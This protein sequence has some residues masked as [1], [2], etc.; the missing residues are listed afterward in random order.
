[1]LEAGETV[2]LEP[3]WHNLLPAELELTGV[4]SDATGPPGPVY[5]IVDGTASYGSIAAGESSNCAEAT[6]DCLEFSLGGARPA[7]HWDASFRETLST[8]EAR[9]WALHVAG[10]FADVPAAHPFYAGVET[11]FH[12]GVTA[13]CGTGSY[14]P[15]EAVRRDQMAGVPSQECPRRPLRSTELQRHLRGRP[16]PEPVRE[17]GREAL[18]RRHH[19][20]VRRG[21]LLPIGGGDPGTDGRLPS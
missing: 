18:R 3:T 13:G 10:S 20:G 14:C 1:L 6:S 4:A 11:L 19:R 15:G 5:Q 2:R 16:V 21:K 7:A 17:M 8:G 9:R 12:H